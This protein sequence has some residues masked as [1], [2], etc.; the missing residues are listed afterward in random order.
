MTTASPP[1]AAAVSISAVALFVHP[2]DQSSSDGILKCPHT[3][4]HDWPLGPIPPQ[5]QMHLLLLLTLRRVPASGD[6]KQSRVRWCID[7]NSV[8][9]RIRFEIISVWNHGTMKSVDFSV[10]SILTSD[11]RSVTSSDLRS[12]EGPSESRPGEGPEPRS[13]ESQTTTNE[14]ARM[15]KRKDRIRRNLRRN[16]NLLSKF[17]EKINRRSLDRNVHP[18]SAQWCLQPP[19]RRVTNRNDLCWGYSRRGLLSVD[20]DAPDVVPRRNAEQTI[21]IHVRPE[22]WIGFRFRSVV[23]VSNRL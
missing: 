9:S 18:P 23:F 15:G 1:A 3:A 16:S 19:C 17:S 22:V 13:G 5:H 14:N 10:K 21:R 2:P 7:A 11:P 4:P 20:C 8:G 6:K 12:E